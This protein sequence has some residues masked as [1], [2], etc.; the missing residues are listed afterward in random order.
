LRAGYKAAQSAIQIDQDS[1]HQAKQKREVN[2]KFEQTNEVRHALVMFFVQIL[3]AY[4]LV[5]PIWYCKWRICRYSE[6]GLLISL[7]HCTCRWNE[8]AL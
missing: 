3:H 6:N 5:A 7:L 1:N 4:K 8:T 2:L